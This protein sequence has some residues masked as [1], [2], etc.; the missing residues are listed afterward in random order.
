MNNDFFT[1]KILP[2]WYKAPSITLASSATG[3]NTLNLATDSQFEWWTLRVNCS[4]DGDTD[5]NPGNVDLQITDQSTGRLL[6]SGQINQRLAAPIGGNNLF[7]YPVVFAPNS[8]V[9]IDYT[10][11]QASENIVTVALFGYKRFLS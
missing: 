10:N 9:V 11:Q 1:D 5:R 7:P 2:F 8:T 3:S 6:M 4:L